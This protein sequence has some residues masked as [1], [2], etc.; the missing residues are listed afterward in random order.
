MKR[1]DLED[2]MFAR[3]VLSA[4]LRLVALGVFVGAHY[5]IN[6]A[7]GK[8]VPP[9]LTG[10]LAAAQTLFFI[11]FLLI[12]GFLAWDMLAVFV[13]R[14]RITPYLAEPGDEATTQEAKSAPDASRE[15][16]IVLG[17]EDEQ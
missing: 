10:A 15:P 11:G 16:D 7:L 17:A 12:Y 13:P 14:W 4:L 2:R 1:D 6:L 8:I 5:L 3:R 9:R